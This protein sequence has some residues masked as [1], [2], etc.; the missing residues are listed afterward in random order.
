MLSKSVQ[1]YSVHPEGLDPTRR[2]R[3]LYPRAGGPENATKS[4]GLD[5]TRRKRK[6]GCTHP[7]L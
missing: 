2:E 3:I 5:P 1:A 6:Q 4:E 7:Q